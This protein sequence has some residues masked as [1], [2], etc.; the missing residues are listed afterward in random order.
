MKLTVLMALVAS[1]QALK[2]EKAPGKDAVRGEK[3]AIQ[4]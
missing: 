1:T 4:D 3:K 2:V